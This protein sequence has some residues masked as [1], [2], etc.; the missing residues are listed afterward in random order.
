M[1]G[2]KNKKNSSKRSIQKKV[3]HISPRKKGHIKVQ[4]PFDVYIFFTTLLLI[5][6]G[7]IMIFSSSAILAEETYGNS[8]H[9]L[10]KEIV[11]IVI[12]MTMLLIAKSVS[13]KIYAKWIYFILAGT[14][15]LMILTFIPGLSH[16]AKGAA[17][18]I[19]LAGFTFQP[20]ELAKLTVVI[21]AAY[22][23]SKKEEKIESFFSGILPLVLIAGVFLT[24]ILAQRDLGSTFVLGAVLFIMLFVAGCKLRHLLVMMI[25]S[26]PAV[27]YLIFSV[28]FRRQRI[29]AFLDPW[30]HQ[31]D[32]GYQIIQ[33]FLAFNSGGMTGV[34]LGESKQKLFY[35]PEAHTDF[36]FSVL[37][38]EF[39]MIGVIIVASLYLFLVSRGL[40]IALKTKD[41]FGMLLALGV[42]CLIGLEAFINF[43]VV[44]GILPTKGLALPFISYGGSSLIISLTAIGILLNVSTHT[45]EDI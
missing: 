39:G 13:Y 10:K 9:F 42:T 4:K 15:F 30:K 38:E 25:A 26:T 16:T 40:K 35:L 3:F 36:I 20:S 8:Y 22:M 29:L 17:R 21:F 45:G 7:V 33:S 27:Y 6:V 5:L 11:F 23:I 18:W 2:F 14:L 1:F 12:G 19:H 31:Q 24:L 43:G 28:E 32:F 34:G 37:G 41:S 44:M